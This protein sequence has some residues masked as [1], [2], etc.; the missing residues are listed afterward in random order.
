[1]TFAC[2]IWIPGVGHGV[3]ADRLRVAQAVAVVGVGGGRGPDDG[4]SQ[5]VLVVS[6]GFSW[7]YLRRPVY[8][9]QPL[10]PQIFV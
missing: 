6:R 4:L 7:P 3:L 5:A 2:G 1:V 9:D 10:E 8:E